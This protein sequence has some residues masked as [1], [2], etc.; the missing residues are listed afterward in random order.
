MET[1]QNETATRILSPFFSAKLL[2]FLG[3]IFT[4]I[5][6]ALISI[7]DLMIKLAP[8]IPSLEVVFIRLIFQL[9]F[10]LPPM[11]FLRDKFIHP[12]WRTGFLVLR[13]VAGVTSLGLMV[14]SLKNMPIGDAR[15]IIC[16]APVYTALLGRI[17][18]KESITKFDVIATMLCLGGVV[19]IAKPTFL[20]GSLS[21]GSSIKR[22]WFPAVMAVLCSIC[23]AFSIVFTRKVSQEVSAR[24]VVFYFAAIGSVVSLCASLISGGFKYPDCR[25]HDIYYIIAYG[26]LGYFAELLMAKALELEKAAVVSLVKTVE[27]ACSFILQI[28]FLD[29][30]PTGLSIG[31]ALLVLLSNIVIFIEKYLDHKNINRRGYTPIK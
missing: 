23:L 1:D 27:I 5:S 20:F 22:E 12:W 6:A 24:V 7:D 17:F 4:I 26:F 13:G 18:L 25:T 2:A 31:G 16:T 15:T 29:V 9:V 21:E 8:S 14:Y 19:L 10:S 11:I 3:I 28:I 30:V